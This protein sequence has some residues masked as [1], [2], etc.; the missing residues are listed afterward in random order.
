VVFRGVDI[1]NTIQCNAGLLELLSAKPTT[2]LIA[3]RFFRPMA[4]T[5]LM[6]GRDCFLN[7]FTFLG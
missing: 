1:A 5:V 2:G 4:A 3:G 7:T 6:D